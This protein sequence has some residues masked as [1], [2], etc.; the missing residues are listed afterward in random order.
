MK[1]I[2]LYDTRFGNTEKTAKSFETGLKEVVSIQA[3]VGLT[4]VPIL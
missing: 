3:A 4:I 1:A 2:V